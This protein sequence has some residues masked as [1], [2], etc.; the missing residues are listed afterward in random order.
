M[1]DVAIAINAFSGDT[2]K[3]LGVTDTKDISVLVPGFTY[4]DG[5][6]SAPIYTLRGVG[7]TDKSFT[8]SPTVGIYIDEVGLP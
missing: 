2:L 3:Q 6:T 1:R 7:F 5:G 8:A 4:A